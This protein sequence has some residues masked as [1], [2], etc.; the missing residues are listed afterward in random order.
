M[1]EN[2]IQMIVTLLGQ[3]INDVHD[4]VKASREERRIQISGLTDEIHTC[5]ARITTLETRVA[6]LSDNNLPANSS[7]Y[8]DFRNKKF[9]GL[10]AIIVSAAIGLAV[11]LWVVI[12]AD[13]PIPKPNGVNHGISS[14]AI[15]Q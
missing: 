2:D 1:G 15:K 9:G 5:N 4:T 12:K 13:N 7:S 11:I 10:A 3:R 6:S 14:N 8:F